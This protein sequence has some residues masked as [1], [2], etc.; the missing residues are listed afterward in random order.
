MV[1]ATLV[2]AH[3]GLAT[4]LPWKRQRKT[5]LFVAGGVV[6]LLMV[7]ALVTDDKFTDVPK[8]ANQL[9]PMSARW[10]PAMST[11]EFGAVARELRNEV[12]EDAEK[13]AAP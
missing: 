11:S 4:A 8:F 12:D 5:G 3:L 7:S 9:K 10:V 1:L 2:S 13:A 6:A